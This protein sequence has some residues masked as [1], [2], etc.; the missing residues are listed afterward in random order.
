MGTSD[1]MN[2]IGDRSHDQTPQPCASYLLRLWQ[3]RRCGDLVWQASLQSVGT[4]ER[5]GFATVDAL[6]AFLREQTGSAPDE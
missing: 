2:T 6:L 4:G 1:G 3:V 5:T